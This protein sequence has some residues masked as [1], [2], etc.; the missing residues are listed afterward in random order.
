MGSPMHMHIEAGSQLVY[1]QKCWFIMPP[2]KG[3]YSAQPIM[4]W[5][6]NEY[7]KIQ[8]LECMQEAGNILYI[9]KYWSHAVLNTQE[10]IGFAR[11]F[12]NPYAV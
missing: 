5:Y 11:D 4:E 7:P 9:P 10:S 6:Q 8:V 2:F 12:L 3:Y 1:G